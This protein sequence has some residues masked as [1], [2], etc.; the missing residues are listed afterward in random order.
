M[1]FRNL[2]EY[3]ENY[4]EPPRIPTRRQKLWRGIKEVAGDIWYAVG[5][6]L[7]FAAVFIVI[8]VIVVGGIM[9]TA[10]HFMRVSCR[11]QVTQTGHDWDYGFIKGCL[12]KTDNGW[13]PLDNWRDFSK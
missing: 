11:Q 13:V 3:A 1:V 4:P 12:I 10:N 6:F 7:S 8:A 9:F 5:D 2:D